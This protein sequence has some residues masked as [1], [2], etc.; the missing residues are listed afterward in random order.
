MKQLYIIQDWTGTKKFNNKTFNSPMEAS[1][2][3]AEQF[4]VI[5]NND[6]SQNDRENDLGE[7]FVTPLNN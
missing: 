3:L 6:G 4:P 7:F 2:F 1:D 5:I